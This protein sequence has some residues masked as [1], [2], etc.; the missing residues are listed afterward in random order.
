MKLVEIEWIDSCSYR[1]WQKGDF[2]L[3][4]DPL[5]C[6]TIGY[7]VRDDKVCMTVVQTVSADDARAESMTIPRACVKKVRCLK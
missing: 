2:H 5:P 7:L 3:D 6:K 1:G 4:I